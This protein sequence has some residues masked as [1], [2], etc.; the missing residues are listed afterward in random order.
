[1]LIRIAPNMFVDVGYDCATIIEV[2]N[3]I[4]KTQK[5]K[6]KY[7]W[8]NEYKNKIQ[9]I[10]YVKEKME[11]AEFNFN[12]VTNL[13]NSEVFNKKTGR[14]FDLSRVDRKIVSY[15][16]AYELSLSSTDSDLVQFLEQEFD[17]K[18]KYPLNILNSW[19]KS[20]LLNYNPSLEEIILDW[21]KDS[22]PNQPK[23]DISEFEKITGHKYL[24]P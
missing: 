14:I 12:L 3:E 22:E 17:K 18:N 16:L 10:P 11:T 7:P 21:T 15:V 19:I 1:M 8:R 4:F 20:G 6:S 9:P 2:K 13:V 23:K 5:F 24:G